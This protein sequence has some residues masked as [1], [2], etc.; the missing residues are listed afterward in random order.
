MSGRR[1][2]EGRGGEG[3]RVCVDWFG[4]CVWESLEVIVVVMGQWDVDG[5]APLLIQAV[6][7]LLAHHNFLR[8]EGK[9]INQ[10]KMSITDECPQNPQERLLVLVVALGRD[11]VIL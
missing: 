1:E 7:L 9:R 2:G 4:G 6:N 11:I 8:S 10:V 5:F 3:E